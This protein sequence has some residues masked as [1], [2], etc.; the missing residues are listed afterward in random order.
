M[1]LTWESFGRFLQG[2]PIS[3]F[4]KTIRDAVRVMRELGIRY[5]WVDAVCIIQDSDEETTVQL[6][7][8]CDIY[9]RATALRVTQSST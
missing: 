6:K 5:L 3:K 9:E 2:V 1:T 7:R 4:G 8:M